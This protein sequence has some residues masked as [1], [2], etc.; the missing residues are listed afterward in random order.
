MINNANKKPID[1]SKVKI[2]F[3]DKLSSLIINI[4]SI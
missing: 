2:Y 3:H 4:L 1:N